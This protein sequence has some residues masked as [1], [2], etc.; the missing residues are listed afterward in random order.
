MSIKPFSIYTR[1]GVSAIA[2]AVVA[3]VPDKPAT[4]QERVI[5]EIIVTS[6]KREQS[7][8]EVP[9]SVSVL[10]GAELDNGGNLMDLQSIQAQVPALTYRRGSGNRESSLI[11]RGIG[12]VSFSTAAEPAV[13]TVIDG[14]VL[15]RSGAAFNELADIERIEVL[16]GPQGTLFG[17]NASAGVI[18]IITKGPTEDFEASAQAS[19]FERS[20]V[21]LKTSI[22]GPVSDSVGV[23]L[24]G[25]YGTFDGHLDSVFTGERAQGYDRSGLRGVV[26]WDA[27]DALTVSFIGDYMSRDDNCCA[28]VLSG[29]PSDALNTIN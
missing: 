27:S 25:F 6:Q 13:A 18:N 5:E 29:P 28:D 21:R 22:S 7:L 12:T 23:R 16:K 9:I 10:G 20:E 2:L 15:S 17:K 19:Y 3:G 8:Q 11:I 1:L 4:A 14:V 26:E 24:N